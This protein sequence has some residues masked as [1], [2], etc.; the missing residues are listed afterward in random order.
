MSLGISSIFSLGGSTSGSSGGGG[1]S[2][3]GIIAINNQLGPAISIVGVSGIGVILSNNIITIFGSGS[4]VNK[5][6]ATFVGI[7]S[8]LFTHNLGTLDVLVQVYDAPGGGGKVIIP[9]QI[10]VENDVQISLRFNRPQ[11]G[12]V[13]II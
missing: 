5:F 4:S 9:D 13:V 10:V 7:T 2:T 11:S 8:G 12:K 1:G 3:S 6:A